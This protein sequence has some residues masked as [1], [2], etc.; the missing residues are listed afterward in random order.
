[1]KQHKKMLLRN[2]KCAQQASLRVD[3]NG[4]HHLSFNPRVRVN[5][6]PIEKAK[7]SEIVATPQRARQRLWR[8]VHFLLEAEESLYGDW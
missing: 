7:N 1:M 2:T 6:L 8:S 5:E 3:Y 4:L